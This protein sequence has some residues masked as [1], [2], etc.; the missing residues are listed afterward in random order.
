MLLLCI[1]YH[2]IFRIF[3]TKIIYVHEYNTNTTRKYITYIQYIDI[4]RACH[5]EACSLLKD[6]HLKTKQKES[7]VNIVAMLQNLFTP[8]TGTLE[9]Y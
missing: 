9:Q 2:I 4:G 3:V 7:W 6:Y 1:L 8:T 5:I